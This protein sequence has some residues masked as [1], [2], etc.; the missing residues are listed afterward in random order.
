MTWAGWWEVAVV[1][2]A[3]VAVVVVAVVVVV[4][5]VVVRPASGRLR[6]Y[7]NPDVVFVADCIVAGCWPTAG[8]P[9]P[10]ARSHTISVTD[11]ISS[12]FHSFNSHK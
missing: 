1:A 7:R 12:N 5:A 3:V 2:V 6:G 10:R 8:L 4:D 9:R 11:K